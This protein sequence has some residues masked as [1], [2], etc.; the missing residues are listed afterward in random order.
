MNKH[1]P[2]GKARRRKSA[3]DSNKARYLGASD[4]ARFSTLSRSTVGRLMKSGRLRFV[5]I[6]PH[7]IRIPVSE[8][9]RLGRQPVATLADEG[10]TE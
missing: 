3:I 7:L 8:I 4:F 1:S 5:R 6:S 10:P 9:Q 2:T